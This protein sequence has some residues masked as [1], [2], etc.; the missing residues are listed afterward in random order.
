[1][2]RN[3]LNAFH[4]VGGF[5]P[6]HWGV[7][8][9]VLILM[10]H[11]FSPSSQASRVSGDQFRE[12]LRYLS[13]NA[14]SISLHEALE[15]LVS[16]APLPPNPVVI[17][18][19]DGYR[20]AYDIALP[21]VREFNFKATLFAVTDFVNGECWVWTDIMRFILQQ[22]GNGGRRTIPTSAGEFDVSGDDSYRDA[23]V[24]NGRL[25]KMPDQQKDEVIQ[26]IAKALN[27]DVP[28]RPT[29]E[30]EPLNL[31]QLRE[32][33]STNIQIESHTVTHPILTEVDEPRLD[34]ELVRSK[35][36]LETML[37]RDVNFFCYPN[38]NVNVSVRDAV[39]RAGYK[40]A[41]TTNFGFNKSP[42][43][44]FMVDRIYAPSSIDDFAQCASGFESLKQMV[45]RRVGP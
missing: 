17:T 11:R 26:E 39:E 13:K 32:M 8:D 16:G 19:D 24:I 31:D 41:L 9:Q 18:I 1:M 35:A 10:Y 28:P 23:D 27:I 33:D 4:K 6:F 12:H 37:D 25:K 42:V 15:A 14:N 40:G 21:L 36:R 29:A 7:R 43:D 3:L 34:D 5:R 20:D 38:G 45:R 22:A 44:P 2:K 30:F